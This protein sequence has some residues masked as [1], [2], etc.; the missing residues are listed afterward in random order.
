MAAALNLTASATIKQAATVYVARLADEIKTAPMMLTHMDNGKLKFG[1]A[2]AGDALAMLEAALG[3]DRT[4]GLSDPRDNDL[5][6]DTIIMAVRPLL[7]P[8]A[9]LWATE[10]QK[11]RPAF[12]VK[13][14]SHHERRDTWSD[15]LDALREHLNV[16]SKTC[17][18]RDRMALDNIFQY[19]DKLTIGDV[20]P[21]LDQLEKSLKFV[22]SHSN[23]KENRKDCFRRCVSVWQGY[24][25][26]LRTYSASQRERIEQAD[27][28]NV[29][30]KFF[31]SWLSKKATGTTNHTLER[32]FYSIA[33]KAAN[34]PS[35]PTN[36]L[37]ALGPGPSDGAYC[38]LCGTANHKTSDCHVNAQQS[39]AGL[40]QMTSLKNQ[41]GNF[42][43]R[44]KIAITNG[45]NPLSSGIF[46]SAEKALCPHCP[47]GT[48]DADR[49]HWSKEC[50][51]FQPDQR[52]GRNFKKRRA[53]VAHLGVDPP[54]RVGP[55]KRA[56]PQKGRDQKRKRNRGKGKNR[57]TQQRDVTI[58]GDQLLSLLA[59]PKEADRMALSKAVSQAVRSPSDSA[60]SDQRRVFL[61]SKIDVG[62]N[63]DSSE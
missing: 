15:W 37:A 11:Q 52:Q 27:D 55:P 39:A 59:S 18:N 34:L 19:I 63:S 49:N 3:N 40:Q 13:T 12:N 10:R 24:V 16:P 9:L 61:R 54:K 62:N 41:R 45:F 50:P 48:S 26:H 43:E 4:A 20:M 23:S 33:T 46:E 47:T 6:S 5:R 60:N 28:W 42:Y 25:R 2:D 1:E 36:T 32:G 56:G 7:P 8:N 51:H 22:Y 53:N 30:R 57:L 35:T 14:L 21:T 44:K 29:E 17:I 38:T 58:D 31:F